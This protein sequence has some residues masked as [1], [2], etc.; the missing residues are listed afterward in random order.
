MGGENTYLPQV[1]Q[2]RH[3]DAGRHLFELHNGPFICGF[4]CGQT[5][6]ILVANRRQQDG[7]GDEAHRDRR[8]R[9]CQQCTGR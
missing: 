3:C 6:A 7:E 8:F 9:A 2:A 5:H 4:G 1:I